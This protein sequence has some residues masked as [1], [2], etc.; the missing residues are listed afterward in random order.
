MN[1]SEPNQTIRIVIA[2]DHPIVRKGFVNVIE[3]SPGLLIVGEAAD[4][5]EAVQLVH[6]K[7]PDILVMDVSMPY[8]NGIEALD[9]LKDDRVRVIIL[10]M[11]EDE[12]FFREAMNAGVWGYLLK[13]CAV[14]DLVKCIRS[15][16]AGKRYVS[17]VLTDLLVG[18]KDTKNVQLGIDLTAGEWRVLRL[19]AENMTSREIADDL[20]LSLRTV[21]NHRANI[22]RKLNIRGYNKLLEFALQ[23]KRE[24]MD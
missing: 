21:Q 2:D 23:H 5:T 6:E 16:A 9:Y 20:C 1:H 3:S 7:D 13:D 15:V 14:E 12:A 4:G 24:L 11:Y 17:P 19:I 8:L 22:C 10:T 18:Q